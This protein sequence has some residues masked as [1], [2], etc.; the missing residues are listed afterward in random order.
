MS[1]LKSDISTLQVLVEKLQ[2]D[3]SNLMSDVV[4]DRALIQDCNAQISMFGELSLQVRR[5]SEEVAEDFTRRQATEDSIAA[6][7]EKLKSL[8]GLDETSMLRS[9]QSDLQQTLATA[10]NHADQRLAEYDAAHSWLPDELTAVRGDMASLWERIEFV[11][12]ELMFEMRY[13]ARDP[14]ASALRAPTTSGQQGRV[15]DKQYVEDARARGCLRVNLGCGHL[16]LNDYINVDRRD[17]PGVHVVAEASSLPFEPGE[18][19]VIHS[20]H[21]LEHFPQERLVRELLPYWYSLLRPGGV[22]SAVVPDA[23]A[24]IRAYVADNYDYE[25]LREVLYGGQDYDGDFHFNM[26]TPKS[27]TSLLGAQGFESIKV[28]AEGR[29]NGNC[30]ECEIHAEKPL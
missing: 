2:Q 28:V 8:G 17:L 10:C 1:D 26:F 21:M 9:L 25:H 5:L 11:R 18:L 19:S 12:R 13:G 7:A 24:M 22:F 29:R 23:E 14:I 30:Y 27:L 15:I 4:L 3:L 16:L 20:A 6:A